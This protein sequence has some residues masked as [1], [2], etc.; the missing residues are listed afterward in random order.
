METGEVLHRDSY[1]YFGPIASLT[2]PSTAQT[3]A[4]VRADEE[5]Y[6]F[7]TIAG[8][9]WDWFTFPATQSELWVDDMVWTE[10]LPAVGGAAFQCSAF[11]LAF[12]GGCA[13]GAGAVVPLRLLMGV[14]L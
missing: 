9:V 7:E 12:Q 8:R 14:G 13:G 3:D 2:P 5:N 6:P 4:A 10:T 1:E 11:D